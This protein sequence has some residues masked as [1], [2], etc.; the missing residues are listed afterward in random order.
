MYISYDLIFINPNIL[1]PVAM[2]AIYA[3]IPKIIFWQT[4]GCWNVMSCHVMSCPKI[5]K[6][7][8]ANIPKWWVGFWLLAHGLIHTMQEIG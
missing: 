2:V 4:L 5:S 7:K 8:F 3:L 1:N 6:S